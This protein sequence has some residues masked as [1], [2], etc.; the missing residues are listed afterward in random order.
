MVWS[1]VLRRLV[2]DSR[3]DG[4]LAPH[5]S[6]DF[7]RWDP[8][9]IPGFPFGRLPSDRAEVPIVSFEMCSLGT[10]LPPP[11]LVIQVNRRACRFGLYKNSRRPHPPPRASGVSR[12]PPQPSLTPCSPYLARPRPPP[13]A[14]PIDSPCAGPFWAPGQRGSHNGVVSG[15]S[16]E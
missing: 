6:V 14:R 3:P 11:L 15:C 12:H 16:A 5:L 10:M 1:S 9:W 8:S 4:M 7:R 2:R 13:S